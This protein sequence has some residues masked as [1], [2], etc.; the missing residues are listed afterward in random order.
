M[1]ENVGR[2]VRRVPLDFA[3]PIGKVW[4][5]FLNPH[6]RPCPECE[7]G[8]S[9]SYNRLQKA[10]TDLM[11]HTPEDG[12]PN[13]AKIT[14]YLAGRAPRGG[15]MGHDS[16]DMWSACKKLGKLAGLPPKWYECPHCQGHGV[17]PLVYEAYEAWKPTGPPAGDGWQMWE[18]TSE[19]SPVSPVFATAEE[20]ARWLAD[21]GASSFGNMTATYEQWLGM[22]REGWAPSCVVEVNPAGGG[23]LKSGVAA[24]SEPKRGD[25]NV[26]T[27]P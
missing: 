11:W 18:T 16:G 5:G 12:D 24:I 25:P 14:T 10:L 21:T 2:E 3:H 19:G 20:L 13:I 9:K 1:G 23:V 22:C 15:F 4:D 6:Y 27:T 8:W 7:A 26:A 17:D